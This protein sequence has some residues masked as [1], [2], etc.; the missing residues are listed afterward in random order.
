MSLYIISFKIFGVEYP[1]EG[2]SKQVLHHVHMHVTYYVFFNDSTD[3]N[4][5]S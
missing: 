4:Q 5:K 1:D 2:K 3:I